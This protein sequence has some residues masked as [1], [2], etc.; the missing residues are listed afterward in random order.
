M[1]RFRFR[2]EPVLRLKKIA[3]EKKLQELSELVAEIN[4]RSSEIENNETKIANLTSKPSETY[5]LREYSYL[6]T[7][8]RQLLTKNSELTEEIRTFDEPIAK[9]RLEVN[10]ARKD[11]KVME[12]LKEKRYSEYIHHYKKREQ[13]TS[14]ELFLSRYF[15]KTRGA[16]DGIEQ[17]GRDPKTF[18]YD[19]GGV[20]RSGS[21]DAGLSELRKLYERY[22][23]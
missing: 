17:I 10:E 4:R 11:K 14:E 18:T 6:Q 15:S 9:K 22:K 1:K 7:Y 5:D 3:E 20:E 2:L 12:L 21:E 8:I 13:Q 16:Q 23:K 19:T